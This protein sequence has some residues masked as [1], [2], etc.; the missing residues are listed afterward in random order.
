MANGSKAPAALARAVGTN[1]TSALRDPDVVR[2]TED[3]VKTNGEFMEDQV[4]KAIRLGRIL[5][6]G[7]PRL[8][9]YYQQWLRESL[10]VEPSTAARYVAVAELAGR[11]TETAR[12]LKDLGLCKAHRLARL[13]EQ[14]REAI[15]QSRDIERL[16]ERQFKE[17]TAPHMKLKRAVSGTMEAVGLRRTIASFDHRL[18]RLRL[19]GIRDAEVRDALRADLVGLARRLRAMAAELAGKEVRRTG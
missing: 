4:E 17:L 10:R 16:S 3:F 6:A 14:G 9:G 7:K 12:R 1:A 5:L 8:R 13:S 19:R 15:L 2:L 18:D 11:S